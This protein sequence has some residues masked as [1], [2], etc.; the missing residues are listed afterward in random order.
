MSTLFAAEDVPAKIDSTSLE[1]VK[2]RVEKKVNGVA[3]DPTG[4]VVQ[5]GFTLTET[6]TGI[7]LKTAD[8]ETTPT[9]YYVRCLVGPG[10][11]TTLTAGKTYYVWVKITD[12]P[13]APVKPGGMLRV[14]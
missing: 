14:T 9:G 6:A 11:T 3:A 4:D 8:W 7:T 13:E 2:C 5:M 10:G 12:T 1:Y